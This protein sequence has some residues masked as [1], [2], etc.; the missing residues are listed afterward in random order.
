MSISSVF[1][2]PLE[3][4]HEKYGVGELHFFSEVFGSGVVGA[5]HAWQGV[6]GA[7]LEKLE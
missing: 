1:G 3:E 7:E 4:L 5:G 6:C 2:V